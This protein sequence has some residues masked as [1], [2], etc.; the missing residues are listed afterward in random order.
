MQWKVRVFRSLACLWSCDDAYL[1]VAW[2][3]LVWLG[4]CVYMH[5]LLA[6]DFPCVALLD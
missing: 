1:A 3:L 6:G 5:A 2:R 4:E